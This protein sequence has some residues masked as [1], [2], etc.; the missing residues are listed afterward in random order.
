MSKP[1]WERYIELINREVVPALGCTE[2]VCVAL[3]AAHAAEA[4]GALPQKMDVLVSGN[5]LKNGKGVAVPGTGAVGLDIAAAAGAFGGK[6]ELGLETLR[7]LSE[8]HVAKAKQFIADDRLTLKLADTDELIYVDV[9]VFSGDERARCVIARA[10]NAVVL[11]ER[12]GQERF[13]APW[14]P[15][16]ESDEDW[17]LSMEGI[18]DFAVNAP[19]ETISFI[20]E[21]AR[22]NQIIAE[23][24]MSKDWGLKVGRSM[25]LD[26][27]SGMRS[28]DIP[29]YAVRL[30][31]SASDARMDGV[32]IPVMSNSGSGNQGIVATVPVTAFARKL[33]IDDEKLARA[34]IMSHMTTIHLKHHLGR[35]SALCGAILAA[36]GAAC[37]IVM[38]LGGGMDEID[39]AIK[40]MVGS[41]AGM[42]CDGAKTS[43]ALKVASAVETGI[44]AAL[45]GM[46]GSSVPGG[47]GI[48]DHDLETCIKNLGELGSQGMAETDKFILNIMVSN[49]GQ[50]QTR[51]STKIKAP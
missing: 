6:S 40:N 32:S 49:K 46:K 36:A 25:H 7:D 12:N 18:H 3:A 9:N 13:S 30:T 11:V 21:A 42:I 8:E 38:I 19:F 17:P 33:D 28:D 47:D 26:V 41:I 22:L 44:N 31:A 51:A 27:E 39:H 1:E 16:R 43:C 4:L 24:G 2:P 48:L 10:H 50:A 5:L 14:P 34:L 23:E 20:L 35:L 45:L 37:G 15:D 29:T